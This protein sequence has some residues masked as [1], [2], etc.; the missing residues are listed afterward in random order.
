MKLRTGVLLSFLLFVTLGLMLQ[1]CSSGGQSA[2]MPELVEY[3]LHI[4]PIF[5][6]R[7]FKCHGPDARQRK[8]DLR[9]DLETDAMAALKKNPGAHAL[10]PGK[11]DESEVFLRISSTDTS[12]LM[13][14]PSSNLAL[15]EFE[16]KLIEKWIRQGAVYQPHWALI[17]PK[18]YPVP[19]TSS[20]WPKNEI[21][22]FILAKL[23]EKDLSPNEEAD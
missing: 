1:R 12:Y 16:V 4:R 15:T 22:N 18:A 19:T 7:C 14:P 13:P 10:V 6:D 11:P 23:N 17:P 21:D 20:D 8:A 9:L 5:S 2:E 3:N